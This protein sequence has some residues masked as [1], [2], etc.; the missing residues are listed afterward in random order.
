MGPHEPMAPPMATWGPQ[1]MR[2]HT[3]T[4]ENMCKHANTCEHMRTRTIVVVFRV[5]TSCKVQRRLADIQGSAGDQRAGLRLLAATLGIS[6][7]GK[8]KVALIADI[9]REA[10]RL[11]RDGALLC[12]TF[13]RHTSKPHG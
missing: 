2:T 11:C 6:Q 5:G 10:A 8:G 13:Q 3:N 1:S 7:K 12:R 4:S 9:K